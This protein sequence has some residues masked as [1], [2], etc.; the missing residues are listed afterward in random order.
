[1]AEWLLRSGRDLLGPMTWHTRGCRPEKLPSTAAPANTTPPSP[2]RIEDSLELYHVNAWG[3]GYF[4]IN[5]AGHVVVRPDT[6]TERQ[7]ISSRWS[8]A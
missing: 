3:K 1:M 5:E 7:S 2:G 4:S 6:Q 8:K